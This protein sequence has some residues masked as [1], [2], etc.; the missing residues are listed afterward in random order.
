MFLGLL[1]VVLVGF[2]IEV[3]EIIL[4]GIVVWVDGLL[5]CE[6]LLKFF[7]IG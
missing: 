4:L 3:V 5:Y 1:I 2:V 7:G 6:I